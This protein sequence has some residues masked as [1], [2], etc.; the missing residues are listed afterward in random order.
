[1]MTR[2]LLALTEELQDLDLNRGHTT[3]HIRITIASFSPFH[4]EQLLTERIRSY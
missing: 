2:Q 3:A 4:E 1:M